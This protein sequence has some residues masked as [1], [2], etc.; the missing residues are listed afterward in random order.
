MP[1]SLSFRCFCI[2]KVTCFQPKSLW[3]RY[4]HMAKNTRFHPE[5]LSSRGFRV[6]KKP[7]FCRIHCHFAISASKITQFCSKFH[8]FRIF[9]AARITPISLEITAI[10]RFEKQLNFSRNRCHFVIF[11]FKNSQIW[12]EIA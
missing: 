5:S 8:T 7:N 6:A 1:K 2:A 9:H 4:F 10:S 12:L 3:F 11:H